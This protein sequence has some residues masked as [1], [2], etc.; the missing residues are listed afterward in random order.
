MR[1]KEQTRDA[2]KKYILD[3]DTTV[4]RFCKDFGFHQGNMSKY[5]AGKRDGFRADTMQKIFSVLGL[6]LEVIEPELKPIDPTTARLYARQRIIKAI[7]AE[8]AQRTQAEAQDLLNEIAREM[9]TLYP[10]HEAE[11]TALYFKTIK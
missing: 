7:K 2:I 11:L 4:Q 5:L 8:H 1:Y 6:K 10:E 9:R 3:N